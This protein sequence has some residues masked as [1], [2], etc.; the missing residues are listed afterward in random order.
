MEIV[1]GCM[2]SRL[3]LGRVFGQLSIACFGYLNKR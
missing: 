3:E 2:G 1:G